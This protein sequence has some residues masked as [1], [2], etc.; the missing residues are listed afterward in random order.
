L[1]NYFI[2]QIPM[3]LTKEVSVFVIVELIYFNLAWIVALAL[4]MAVLVATLTTFGQM[5]SDN[6]ITAMK[7]SGYGVHQAML[8]VLSLAVFIAYGNFLFNDA[9]LPEFNTK[10]RQLFMDI[11]LKNPNLSF[12]E[13]I[14]SDE[15]LIKNF[16]IKFDRIDRSS[17]RVFGVTIHD[18]SNP[19]IVRTLIAEH[20]TLDSHEDSNQIIMDLFNGETHDVDTET[21]SEY[22]LFTFERQRLRINV[23]SSSLNRSTAEIRGD[24]EKKHRD[25]ARRCG[26]NRTEDTY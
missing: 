26:A 22:K 14:F 7:A 9:V 5:S 12:E 3:L 15:D 16:R 6:E 1:T 2:K 20:A 11:N 8:P 4:P 18:Y 23:E 25:V 21:L 17:N 13:G 19:A 24:R 10:A